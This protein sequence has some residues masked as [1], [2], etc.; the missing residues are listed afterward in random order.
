MMLYIEFASVITES[1]SKFARHT[2]TRI[3]LYFILTERK[4][5]HSII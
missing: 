4:D 3:H 5:H 1:T 2:R